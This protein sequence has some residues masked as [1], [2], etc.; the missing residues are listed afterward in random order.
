MMKPGAVTPY[1]KFF[2]GT[3]GGTKLIVPYFID[4]NQLLIDH[5]G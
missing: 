4:S 2:C 3:I 5:F 1:F